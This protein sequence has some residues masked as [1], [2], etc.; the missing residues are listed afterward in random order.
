M[1]VVSENLMGTGQAQ[2]KMQKAAEELAKSIAKEEASGAT[3]SGVV[4]DENEKANDSD[5]AA[6]KQQMRDL[7]KRLGKMMLLAP[8]LL[9]SFNV[10]NMN[11][12]GGGP[13]PLE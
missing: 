8:C 9:H 7:I 3:G 1:L 12:P 13:A 11:H 2:A 10:C 5:R 6:H 4:G